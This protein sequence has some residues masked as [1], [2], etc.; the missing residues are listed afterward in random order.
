MDKKN[1][2]KISFWILNFIIIFL[3]IWSLINHR[4]LNQEVSNIVATFG[5]VAMILFVV[6]LEGA[7]VFI[8][9]S[10]AVASILAMGALNP[11]TI[12]FLFLISAFVGNVFYYYL[13]YFSGKK[14]LKYFSDKDV[15]KYK[16]F[17]KNHGGKTL[18]IMAISPVPYL[19]TLAGVFKL[20]SKSIMAYI[21]LV[22]ALRHIVVFAFWLIILNI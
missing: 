20:K 1:I 13:G 18:G 9:P 3:L 7:P 11:W 21:L 10:V 2:V 22:R 16:K 17:F 19:P 14:I 8:G 15:E 5:L 12:L 4:V 6:I